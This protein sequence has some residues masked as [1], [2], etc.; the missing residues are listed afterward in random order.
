MSP[1]HVTIG[2]GCVTVDPVDNDAR[3]H[4]RLTRGAGVLGV[5]AVVVG[6]AGGFAAGYAAHDDPDASEVQ[7]VAGDSPAEIGGDGAASSESAAPTASA[8]GAD[9]TSSATVAPQPRLPQRLFLRTTADGLSVRVFGNEVLQGEQDCG[10]DVDWCPPRECNPAWYIEATIVG[11]WSVALGGAPRWELAGDDH[12]R[13]LGTISNWYS[14]EPLFGVIVRAAPAVTSTRLTYGGHTDEMVPIDG[15]AVLA[16]P[17]PT[18]GGTTA[19]QPYPADALV[20]AVI[21][22]VAAPVA[23]GRA[24]AID[25]ACSPPPPAP[26]SLPE[27]GAQPE[28]RPAAEAAVVA[29]F[30]RAFGGDDPDANLQAIDD[31]SGLADI[32]E[33]LRQRYPEML[34]GRVTYEITDVVFTSP[35]EASYYF[36]PVIEDY[37]ELPQQIGRARVVDGEWKITRDT[38]CAM[39]GLGG[40]TC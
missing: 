18:R 35:A 28:D 9:T 19:S 2:P 26:P 5:L 21:D 10:P 7:A 23:I 25:S 27:P 24:F 36:R 22:G 6:F 16:V 4:P 29:A 15:L 30:G 37:N 8:S 1:Q 20:E 40:I 14:D 17:D 34:G 3:P 39:F 31:P 33:Q 12:A 11:E 38:A 13:V 32:R